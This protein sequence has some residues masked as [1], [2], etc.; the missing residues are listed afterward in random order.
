MEM[1]G[2]MEEVVECEVKV[3]GEKKK[4]IKVVDFDEWVLRN[5]KVKLEVVGGCK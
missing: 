3:G 2:E 5:I 4:E 1:D